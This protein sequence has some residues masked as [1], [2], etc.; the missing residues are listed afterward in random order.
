MSSLKSESPLVEDTPGDAGGLG[1]GGGGGGIIA[2][3]KG[4]LDKFEEDEGSITGSILMLVP[5]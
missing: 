1:R 3:S 2:L 5:G 4:T